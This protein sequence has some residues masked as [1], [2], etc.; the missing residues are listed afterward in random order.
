MKEWSEISYPTFFIKLSKELSVL[1]SK[2]SENIYK[3]GTE[4][5]RGDKEEKI[6]QLGVLAELIAQNY[7]TETELHFTSAPIVDT[8]PVVE[9]DIRMD[10][11]LIDVKGVKTK[12]TKLRVN[13]D[14]HNN[15]DKQITHYLFI[16][17]TSSDKARYKWFSYKE[18]S[19]WDIIHS[20]YSK[21]YAID[22]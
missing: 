4:K 9:C 16:H 17:I 11:Y 21:C 14:A 8:A 18:V 12:D 20:T 19:D 2:L 1:R 22:I 6:S 7:L 5:Y 15:S 13:Y 10:D 3:E